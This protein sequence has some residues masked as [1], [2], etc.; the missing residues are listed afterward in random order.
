VRLPSLEARTCEKK[1]LEVI[2]TKVEWK[3]KIMMKHD[4][5]MLNLQLELDMLKSILEGER[6][7]DIVAEK[8]ASHLSNE[9]KVAKEKCLLICSRCEDVK[10]EL[11]HAKS[12]MEALEFQQCLSI[13][14]TDE[15]RDSNN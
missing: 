6:L 1:L 5:E 8:R 14:Q 2:Q 9:L 3:H 4:E 13:S 7:S 11:K 10:N 12:I 15:L